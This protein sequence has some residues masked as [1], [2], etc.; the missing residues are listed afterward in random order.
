MKNL[1]LLILLFLS[2]SVFGQGK[3]QAV[4]ITD[5]LLTYLDQ[6]PDDDL[7]RINIR[8]KDQFNNQLL[9]KQLVFT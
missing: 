9:E 8:L 1:A 4:P 2:I 7:I 3:Y 6:R 5:D